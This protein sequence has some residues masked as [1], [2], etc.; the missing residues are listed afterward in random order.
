MANGRGGEGGGDA[1]DVGLV[2]A[3]KKSAAKRARGEGDDV[4]DA[5][6]GMPTLTS[7]AAGRL[8]SPPSPSVT[9][10]VLKRRT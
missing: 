10:S 2:S 4:V 1:G 3:N 8:M 6:L 7:A 5:S 9:I